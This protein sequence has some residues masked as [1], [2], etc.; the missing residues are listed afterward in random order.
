MKNSE[1][2]TK[3]IDTLDQYG[4]IQKGY[5]SPYEGFCAIGA[6]EYVGI[7]YSSLQQTDRIKEKLTLSLPN[8][9]IVRTNDSFLGKRKIR[10]AIKKLIKQERKIERTYEFNLM[11]NSAHD[12]ELKR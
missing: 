2:L 9:S 1:Y 8:Y 4:H 10:K 11:T 7:N 6:I 5:G 12:Y 3:V